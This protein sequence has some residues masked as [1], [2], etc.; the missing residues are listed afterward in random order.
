MTRDRRRVPAAGRA[1]RR[2]EPATTSICSCRCTRTPRRAASSPGSRPTSLDTA[3]RPADRAGRGARERHQRAA[4][5]RPAHAARVAASSGTTNGYAAQY[6]NLVQSS[7]IRR[8]RKD[9]DEHHRPRREA[10]AVPGAVQARTCR[11]SWSRSASCRT[12]PR[13]RGWARAGSPR[14]R[15]G[16]RRRRLGVSRAAGAPDRREA[17][18]QPVCDDFFASA[19]RGA[20]GPV[21]A[22][23]EPVGARLSR[24]RARASARAPRRGRARA[25]GER[26]ARGADGPPRAQALPASPRTATSRTS[27]AS[28]SASR[29][30]PSAATA[31]ASS[32]SARTSTS[33]SCTAGKENPYVET[34]TE[35]ITTRL[36]D[37]RVVVG[38]AT[39][40]VTECPAR[41]PR[42]PLDPD[43]V[44]R[45]PLPGRRPG[46][47]RRARPRRARAPEGARGGVH[48]R[49][50]R[51]AGQ[52]PRG[53]R[54][55]ALPAAAEPEGERRRP[56]RLPHRALGRARR[57]LGGA[58]RRAPAR[59][60]LHR[61]RRGARAALGARLPVAACATSST[62]RAASDDRL[63]YEAQEQLAEYLGFASED[64]LRRVEMLMRTLLPARARDPARVEARDRPRAPA[65]SQRR[66][67]QRTHPVA[68]R[69]R[70]QRRAARDPCG[71]AGRGAARAPARRVRGRAA[72]RRRASPRAQR[73]IRQHLHRIDDAFRADPEASAFFR[74]ILASPTRVYRTLQ[75]M[76]EI[77]LLAPTC[78]S[79]RTWSACG[80]RTCTTR[81]P[82]TF[83]RCSWSSSC[84]GSSAAAT[85]PS[86]RSRPS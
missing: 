49:E 4:A 31:A 24:R 84:G 68:G 1:H 9:Y 15:G 45:R 86:C 27:R 85:A 80:S 6:A 11:R 72:P 10:R 58:P 52:A 47:V 74:Q 7:L 64:P 13:V 50:A 37:G 82:S 21:V 12:P 3:L 28:T 5:L 54:R 14:G 19:G 30:S 17:L 38:A 53:L 77:G 55:V 16:H 25:Q 59:A 61:R 71:V 34:I 51:R 20:P 36:W 56:A 70:D 26:G 33:C 65:A 43:L 29:W 81:T 63:H 78:R 22:V 46:P 69:L 76:D 67:P 48:R 39:R 60:G 32:R 18:V 41:R 40:S 23:P 62:A 44:P 35:T 57:A 66:G 42:R 8:L 83:T 79:S 2:R 75:S 73:L